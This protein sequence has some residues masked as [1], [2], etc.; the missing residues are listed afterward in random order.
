MS[1]W[2]WW[3]GGVA[4]EWWW[5]LRL[6]LDGAADRALL[7]EWLMHNHNRFKPIQIQ[8]QISNA[9]QYMDVGTLRDAIRRGAFHRR[10]GPGAMAVDL[11]G[12]VKVLR[13][14]ALA[15]AHLHG[16]NLLHCDVKVR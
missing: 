10:V 5:R 9:D 2:W 11:T 8:I 15:V 6:R 14:A 13:E 4:V 1:E 12:C 16:R 7:F 3:S